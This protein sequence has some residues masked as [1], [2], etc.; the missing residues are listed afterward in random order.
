MPTVRSIIA[1]STTSAAAGLAP[2]GPPDGEWSGF[3]IH[4]SAGEIQGLPPGP[5]RVGDKQLGPGQ[6]KF[7][8]LTGPGVPQVLVSGA[9]L[10]RHKLRDPR[11]RAS[12]AQLYQSI[13]AMFPT[14]TVSNH[15]LLLG[16][17]VGCDDAAKANRFG[18]KLAQIETTPANLR[19][20]RNPRSE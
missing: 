7:E 15:A 18:K 2:C 16:A 20:M 6:S 17:V 8:L 14:T 13:Q 19:F 5:Y 3:T 11:T 10:D 9:D 4:V 1:R 12:H